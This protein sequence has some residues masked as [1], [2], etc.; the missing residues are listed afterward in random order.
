MPEENHAGTG[1][2][3]RAP[4][5]WDDGI[6]YKRIMRWNR[7]PASPDR[8]G[9][10][11]DVMTR[12]HLS[13]PP[14]ADMRHAPARPWAVTSILAVLA[15]LCAVP[16]RAMELEGKTD[17]IDVP[18][19]NHYAGVM[20]ERLKAIGDEVRKDEVLGRYRLAPGE[21]VAIREALDA[22][23]LRD[24][25][26]R[27]ATLD[28]Q[29]GAQA[30]EVEQLRDSVRAGYESPPRLQSEEAELGLLQVR[31]EEALRDRKDQELRLAREAARISENLQG[32]KVTRSNVPEVVPLRA[33]FDGVIST[34]VP[35][36]GAP[37]A[38]KTECF[39]VAV[40]YVLVKAKAYAEDYQKLR[41]GQKARATIQDFP[42]QVFQAVLFILPAKPVDKGSVASSYYEVQFRLI[43]NEFVREGLSA[44]VSVP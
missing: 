11:S 38:A 44:R 31:R 29:I 19:K 24:L 5:A 23:G 3:P 13:I 36:P 28:L 17:F 20:A 22:G 4:F 37:L 6:G 12:T 32:L 42:G 30:Q 2:C 33:P 39:R 40:R 41:V 26:A 43:T 27:I 1:I 10:T 16:A 7:R 34:S 8:G 9:T 14:R 35:T 18:V 15:L 25:D 21:I